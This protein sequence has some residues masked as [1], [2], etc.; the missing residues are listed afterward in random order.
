MAEFYEITHRKI[1]GV[2]RKCVVEYLHKVKG[3]W[4]RY[5]EKVIILYVRGNSII[6]LRS[7]H[8]VQS[9]KQRD[10][11]GC[12]HTCKNVAPNA[13]LP[14]ELQSFCVKHGATRRNH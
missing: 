11:P 12:D 8:R 2:L 7:I 4:D 6:I 14:H 9:V 10:A 1:I 13:S 5:I 3:K